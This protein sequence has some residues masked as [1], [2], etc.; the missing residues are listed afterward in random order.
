MKLFTNWTAFLVQ[1]K[2]ACRSFVQN[3]FEAPL[4]GAGKMCQVQFCSSPGSVQQ[5]HP[6]G[7]FHNQTAP[8]ALLCVQL[9]KGNAVE[10]EIIK[11]NVHIN[12]ELQMDSKTAIFEDPV[13]SGPTGTV[14]AHLICLVCNA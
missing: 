8:P 4:Q 3:K 2:S 14:L 7:W 9:C 13:V 10:E 12:L 5:T 11:T 1:Q 6:Q